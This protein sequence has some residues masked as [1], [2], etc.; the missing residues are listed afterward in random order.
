MCNLKKSL[1]QLHKREHSLTLL[2]EI[3]LNKF[4]SVQVKRR[5]NCLFIRQRET[6]RPHLWALPPALWTL[7]RRSRQ[8]SLWQNPWT[9]TNGG[10]ISRG[11]NWANCYISTDKPATEHHSHHH[12]S[13]PL[14]ELITLK[15]ISFED[16]NRAH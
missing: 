3:I 6:V 8:K 2:A 10:G 12:S 7:Q 15:I 1:P 16:S 9:M 11:A 5:R 14:F 13:S 4:I